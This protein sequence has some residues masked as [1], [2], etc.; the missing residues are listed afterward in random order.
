MVIIYDIT[1]ED[2][3]RSV[4]PWLASIQEA[5]GEPIPVMV[6][7]NKSDKEDEREVQTKQAEIL[8]QVWTPSVAFKML[9]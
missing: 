8:A 5:V 6:L 1:A 4:R 7:G 2:S 9:S 3:F